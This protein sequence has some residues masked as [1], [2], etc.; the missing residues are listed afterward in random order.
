MSASLSTALGFSRL[1]IMV[2]VFV[3][4]DILIGELEDSMHSNYQVRIN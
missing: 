4:R 1:N 2:A 3:T